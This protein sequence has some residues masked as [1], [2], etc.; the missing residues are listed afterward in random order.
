MR[1]VFTAARASCTCHCLIPQGLGTTK[2]P[3]AAAGTERLL[4]SALIS[5]QPVT[6]GERGEELVS[7]FICKLRK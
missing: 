3:G 5:V 4:G 1:E 2:D 7:L 6:V